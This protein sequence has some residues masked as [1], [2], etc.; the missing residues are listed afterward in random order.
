[1][2]LHLSK[3]KNFGINVSRE[4]SNIVKMKSILNNIIVALFSQFWIFIHFSLAKLQIFHSMTHSVKQS[5]CLHIGQLAEEVNNVPFIGQKIFLSV[6]SQI[7]DVF[8][9]ILASSRLLLPPVGSDRAGK[10]TL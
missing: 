1:M 6:W 7:R 8:L 4:S 3:T 2:D 10:Q 9:Q 5:R